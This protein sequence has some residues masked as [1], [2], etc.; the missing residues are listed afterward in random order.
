MSRYKR[1]TGELIRLIK[2][3]NLI[4][5]ILIA[6]IDSLLGAMSIIVYFMAR[7]VMIFTNENLN[8]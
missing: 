5:G 4:E 6:I 2:H 1:V 7:G 3:F 8:L